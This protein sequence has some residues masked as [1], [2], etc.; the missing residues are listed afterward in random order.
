MSLTPRTRLAA[1]C[2]VKAGSRHHLAKTVFRSY[3]TARLVI[4][5][6]LHNKLRGKILRK[7]KFHDRQRPLREGPCEAYVE[8]LDLA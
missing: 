5:Q 4:P 6:V 8:S 7:I 3:E 2:S 1:T